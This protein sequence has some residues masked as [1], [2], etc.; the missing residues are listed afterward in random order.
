LLQQLL[1]QRCRANVSV[2]PDA[3]DFETTAAA[4]AAAHAAAGDSAAA[5]ASELLLLS[6]YCL[7]T[8]VPVCRF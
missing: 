7:S 1:L 3:Y 8:H 5:A 4:I 6:T 2:N